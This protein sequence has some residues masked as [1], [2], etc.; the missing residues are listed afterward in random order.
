MNK[1]LFFILLLEIVFLLSYPCKVDGQSL[2]LN[3]HQASRSVLNQTLPFSE[4][5][6]SLSF[7]TNNWVKS[8]NEWIIDPDNGKKLIRFQTTEAFHG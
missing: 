3:N 5:W 8:G 4:D 2:V 7:A 1:R 6:E